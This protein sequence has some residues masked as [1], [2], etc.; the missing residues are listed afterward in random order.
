MRGSP[1][2]YRYLLTEAQRRDWLARLQP[3][4][5]LS[6]LALAKEMDLDSAAERGG[7]DYHKNVAGYVGDFRN[8]EKRGLTYFFEAPQRL[9]AL[10]GALH[11]TPDD[12]RADLRAVLRVDRVDED[13]LWLPGFEDLGPVHFDD[14]FVFP[15]VFSSD[16]RL[17]AE[18]LRAKL[19]KASTGMVSVPASPR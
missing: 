3:R 6:N 15:P 11:C 5:G 19:R 13:V 1:G 16:G 2:G 7:K 10:A 18:G 12:L 17:D 9:A 4:F 8:G 14:G